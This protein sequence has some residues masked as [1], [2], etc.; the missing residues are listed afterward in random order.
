MGL[1]VKAEECCKAILEN[2]ES[3][4]EA[5]SLVNEMRRRPG[6]PQEETRGAETPISVGKHKS[7]RRTLPKATATESSTTA[8]LAPHQAPQPT[9]RFALDKRPTQQENI[10]QMFLQRQK[11]AKQAKQGEESSRA[12]RMMINKSLIQIFREN[13]IFYPFDKHHKFYGYSKEARLLG[14]RPK[15]E[16]D[17]LTARS[18]SVLGKERP[19]NPMNDTCARLLTKCLEK[20]DGEQVIIPEEFNGISFEDWLDVFLEHGLSLVQEGD[21]KSAYETIAAAFH[22]NIFYHSPE[23]LFSIHVCWF[24]KSNRDSRYCQVLM[25]HK[26][27]ALIGNDDEMLCNVARWFMKEYQFVTDS[28]RLFAALNR[29]CE[30]DNSW[31]NCGPSQK[32]ILRQLK[33]VDFSFVGDAHRKSLFQER[34]SYTTKD[35]NGNPVHA[36]EMDVALLML[37]GHILYAGKSYAYAVSTFATFYSGSGSLDLEKLTCGSLHLD[38][39]LRALSLDS[40]NPL[41]KL[42]LALAYIHYALKRQADNRHHILMQG[43]AFLM[44]YYD[45]RQESGDCL[46]RQEA[47]YNVGRAYHLLGLTH[48]AIPYYERCLALSEIVQEDHE[49]TEDFAQEAAFAMQGLWAGSGNLEKA[50]QV[51]EAWLSI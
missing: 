11:L 49:Y 14:S 40:G 51:T 17:K 2:D 44:E 43:F 18:K 21:I 5:R 47:E 3:N 13:K 41:I 50:Q 46:E 10:Y 6:S 20:E 9:K 12:Q 26:A 15:H 27:C 30:S 16:L 35:S 36:E 39:F 23:A 29:L 8:M 24:S 19:G 38:Y 42:S 48:L 1:G 37:Y 33:A 28:Y 31:Y 45:M 7:R 22:A 32:Y 4:A 25:Y 34:A